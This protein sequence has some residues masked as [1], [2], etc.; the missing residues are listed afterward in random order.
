MI[1]FPPVHSRRGLCAGG[2]LFDE[3]EI[4][5]SRF[6]KADMD[7]REMQTGRYCKNPLTYNP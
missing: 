4:F 6:A 2:K 7:G 1:F 3:K 5:R